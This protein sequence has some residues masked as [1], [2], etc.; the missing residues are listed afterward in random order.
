[1]IQFQCTRSDGTHF[2]VNRRPKVI[3]EHGGELYQASSMAHAA[4]LIYRFTGERFTVQQLY[5]H[6]QPVRE[7]LASFGIVLDFLRRRAP[8]LL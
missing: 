5:R 3:V 7:K 6:S 1:M 2:T 4:D 8:R